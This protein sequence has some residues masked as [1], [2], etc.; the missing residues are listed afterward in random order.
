MTAF[1]WR[2]VP[3]LET[4]RLILRALVDSDADELLKIYGDPEVVRFAADPI[5]TDQTYVRLMLAD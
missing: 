2:A 3:T 1:A 4:P 5:F